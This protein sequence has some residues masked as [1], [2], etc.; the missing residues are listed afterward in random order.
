MSRC[1]KLAKRRYGRPVRSVGVDLSAEARGTGVAAIDWSEEG[2]RLL[3]VRV[4]AGDAIV[5]QAIQDADRAAIDCPLGWPDPLIDFL[6]RI[7]PVGRLP[8]AG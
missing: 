1:F 2:A 4:G 6:T 7:E 3:Y 5:L 8:R